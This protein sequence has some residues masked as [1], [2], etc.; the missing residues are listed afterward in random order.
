MQ[1][2]L[3]LTKEQFANEAFRHYLKTG[4]GYNYEGYL[5]WVESESLKERKNQ[6]QLRKLTL[7]R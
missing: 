7:A 3:I 5:K 4:Q 6:N 1:N 2:D